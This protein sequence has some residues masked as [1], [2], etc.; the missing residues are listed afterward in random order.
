MRE[1]QRVKRGAGDPF[2]RVAQRNITISSILS[3]T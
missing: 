3:I 1:E 2:N